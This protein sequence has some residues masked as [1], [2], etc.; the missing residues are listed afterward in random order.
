MQSIHPYSNI[1]LTLHQYSLSRIDADSEDLSMF[2]FRWE[3][4]GVEYPLSDMEVF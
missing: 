4:V 3:S 1:Q 2:Q